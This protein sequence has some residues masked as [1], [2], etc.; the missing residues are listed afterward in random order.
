MAPQRRDSES[1]NDSEYGAR[2]ARYDSSPADY[3]DWAAQRFG[4]ER[5]GWKAVLDCGS[6]PLYNRYLDFVHRMALRRFI[7]ASK[8]RRVLDV[9]C[10]VGRWT[11]RF[12]KCG[13][14]VTGVD[15]SQNMLGI[16]R[17]SIDAQGSNTRLAQMCV[18]NLGFHAD[19][20]DLIVCVVVLL[21]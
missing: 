20:F 15:R 8:G 21:H 10:G 1:S 17:R 12:A 14:H 18:T 7:G 5:E 3:W 19:A 16:A 6:S 11:A 9:G 2:H 4:T 13:A